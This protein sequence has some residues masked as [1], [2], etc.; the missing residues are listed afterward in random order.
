MIRNTQHFENA[1]IAHTT[2]ENQHWN[3]NTAIHT[4][5]QLINSQINKHTAI[6]TQYQIAKQQLQYQQNAS[7][8]YWHTQNHVFKVMRK[9]EAQKRKYTNNNNTNNTN[10]TNNHS[11]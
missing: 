8:T 6:L 7:D 9:S 2:Q 1:K 10:N 11:K 4:R 5:Q 3:T